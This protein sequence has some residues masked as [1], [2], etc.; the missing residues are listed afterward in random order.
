[1]KPKG[2]TRVMVGLMVASMSLGVACRGDLT[3]GSLSPDMGT[4]RPRNDLPGLPN[5]ARL[6]DGLYRGAQPTAEGFARLKKM[7]VKTVANLR[8]LHS[9][10]E[11]M[12][13]LGLDYAHISFKP[14]MAEDEDVTAFMKVATDPDRR[15]VLVHCQHGADRTG[16]MAAVYRVYVQG[17]SME[18]ALKELPAFGFHEIWANLP[19]YLADMDLADMKRQ[20][21]QASMPALERI[22]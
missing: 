15:P 20:V 2:P 18:R 9:D 16:T 13:G 17:W 7:G 8:S 21:E 10:R 5:F 11:E 19:R 12:K 1:M 6:D 3:P 4:S 14:F 22:P